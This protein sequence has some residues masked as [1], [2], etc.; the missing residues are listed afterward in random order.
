MDASD[1][2]PREG[3][4]PDGST[5][6]DRERQLREVLKSQTNYLRDRASRA[7][8][9]DDLETVARTYRDLS[10]EAAFLADMVDALRERED[11]G[12]E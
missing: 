6:Y 1:C 10:R 5:D 3:F 4:S 2:T 7:A 8:K 12:D 11:R 9:E